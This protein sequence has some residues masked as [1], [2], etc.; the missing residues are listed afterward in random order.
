[1][2]NA[3]IAVAVFSVCL[4]S[5]A[6]AQLSTR[7]FQDD[8]LTTID[9]ARGRNAWARRC[10]LITATREAYLNTENEYQVFTNGCFAYPAVPAGSSCTF[11]V[12]AVES[13]ECITGLNKL[14]T[15][16]AGCTTPSQKVAFGG[17]MLP[18]PEAYASGLTTVTALSPDSEAG[19]L[20]YGEQT[21]R[22]FVAGDT[23]EDIFTLETQ[24]G[25]RLE[26][27]A[28]H[29]MVLEDGTMVKART[30]QAGDTLLG[31]DGVKLHLS[32]VTVFNFKGQVWNV[33]PE[34]QVKLENVMN[35]EGF[36]T[37]SVRFQNEWAQDDYRLS[38]RDD[39]DVSGL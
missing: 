17:R 37:G 15:C 12:P 2:K 8:Q 28:E 13:A 3:F 18:V 38:L 5:T 26:V 4:S 23:Q 19:F 20:R 10:G 11:F 31:A 35:A 21:I 6:L 7:C 24:E 33:R 25:R 9:L 22:S 34:S 29:P 39:V 30:L 1:M 36:L 27:T 16:V 32:R 14:G